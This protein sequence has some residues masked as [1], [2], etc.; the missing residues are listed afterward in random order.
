MQLPRWKT[1]GQIAAYK[2][3]A[4]LRQYTP[5]HSAP[6]QQFIPAQTSDQTL[7]V[8][9][10][11]SNA[12]SSGLGNLAAAHMAVEKAKDQAELDY[13]ETEYINA[14]SAVESGIMQQ[15]HERVKVDPATGE[16]EL[17]YVTGQPVIERPYETAHDDYLKY[18]QNL[19]T[20][21]TDK[22]ITSEKTKRAFSKF[23]AGKR[24]AA[25][26]RIQKWQM[27]H[28]ADRANSASIAAMG[29]AKTHQRVEEIANTA[30]QNYGDPEKIGKAR[31]EN[32][33]R[34]TFTAFNQDLAAVNESVMRTSPE[35]YS[36]ELS[37]IY[38]E[39][40]GVKHTLSADQNN[41]ILK[42][43]VASEKQWWTRR[44]PE[45]QEKRFIDTIIGYANG[46]LQER[47]AYRQQLMTA[48]AV[49]LYGSS[50]PQLIKTILD[51][52]Q[53]GED[54]PQGMAALSQVETDAF[55]GNGDSQSA[56][57]ATQ[58]IMRNKGVH[59]KTGVN[60]IGKVLGHYKDKY[61]DDN[62]LVLNLFESSTTAVFTSGE[63]TKWKDVGMAQIQADAQT[64]LTIMKARYRRA[65]EKAIQTNPDVD[66]MAIARDVLTTMEL[67]A[68]AVNKEG[69]PAAS[70]MEL[71]LD[72]SMKKHDELYGTTMN[73]IPQ[74]AKTKERDRYVWGERKRQTMRILNGL[75]DL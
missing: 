65:V 4:Q 13:A 15:P 32:L 54:T 48:D 66:R 34:I 57:M 49:E 64:D 56:I 74:A 22:I 14:S 33:Q 5:Q 19:E 59:M 12:I 42:G 2:E 30:L 50:A 62:K 45:L 69:K 11:W 7:R 72:L 52:E 41:T 43:L 39:W 26:M 55:W 27:G 36:S 63:A 75:G 40:E 16:P 8:G 44:R 28:K 18:T 53:Y 1:T 21:I 25:N 9:L 73:G 6:Q 61:S 29:N 23:V 20:T 35:Q 68:F 47:A 37:R 51:A 67:P 70:I 10:S 38:S 60:A 17:N 24:T 46:D 31:T 3:T 58:E 71:D